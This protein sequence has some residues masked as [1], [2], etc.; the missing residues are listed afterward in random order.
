MAWKF[1]IQNTRQKSPID[2]ETI[3][4]NLHEFTSEVGSLNEHNW[5]GTR[6]INRRKTQIPSTLSAGT[7]L[8]IHH[9]YWTTQHRIGVVDSAA[10][11][12]P[13]TESHGVH[14]ESHSFVPPYGPASAV[15][16]VS[17]AKVRNK[18]SWQVVKKLSGTTQTALMWVTCSF[19][20]T[21]ND[22]PHYTEE[23]DSFD[24]NVAK[25]CVQY[26]LRYNGSVIWETAT[27]TAESDND[28]I[29]DRELHGPAAI[30]L[31]AVIPVS[32]GEFKLE[33][34][35]R[36]TNSEGFTT[37]HVVH[38]DLIAFEFRR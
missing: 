21:Q 31:D 36:C 37:G 5:S 19:L 38:G 3:N 13:A 14:T 16:I 20:H 35:G 30:T 28:P 33:L 1:P 29:A 24:E 4:D 27:G 6:T 18:P 7:A 32:A 10:D 11:Y 34:L 9:K 26:V 15:G 25:G 12:S 2:I 8:K 23:A 17:S 22:R